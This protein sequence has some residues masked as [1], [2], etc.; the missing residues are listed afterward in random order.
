[1]KLL[2]YLSAERGRQ[3]ALAKTLGVHAPDLSR[4]AS[5]ARPVPLE[6]CA[7]IERATGGAVTR[8]DL[9]PDDWHL[10]WP[11]LVSAEHPAPFP[12]AEVQRA[13]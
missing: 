12:A 13:A 5:G 3:S 9:R 1:M 8:R 11:E 10:I 2:D 7:A 6:H 4:W